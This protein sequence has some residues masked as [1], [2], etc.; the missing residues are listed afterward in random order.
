M[1]FNNN[2]KYNFLFFNNSREILLTNDIPTSIM[3]YNNTNLVGYN[4]S[5]AS[6]NNNFVFKNGD[7]YICRRQIKGKICNII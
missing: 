7:F 5:H 4:K 2:S 3:K 1:N 6:Y